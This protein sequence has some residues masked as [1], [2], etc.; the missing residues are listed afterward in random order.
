MK[1]KRRTV[2]RVVFEDDLDD[3]SKNYLL[4]AV[5]AQCEEDEEGK[6]LGDYNM[7]ILTEETYE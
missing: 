4:Y 6:D 1:P 2:I 3:V 5:M 7:K